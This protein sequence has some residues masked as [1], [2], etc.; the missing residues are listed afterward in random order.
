MKLIM[1][2]L[3][4]IQNA[5]GFLGMWFSVFII[6]IVFHLALLILFLYGMSCKECCVSVIME[7]ICINYS[8][9]LL[10][11]EREW[12]LWKRLPFQT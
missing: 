8:V 10:L 4:S 2:E 3:K 7:C 1:L 11:Y 9:M 5:D 6:I 12:Y